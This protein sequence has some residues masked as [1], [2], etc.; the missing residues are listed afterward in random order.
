MGD[1]L[2]MVFI[3][4]SIQYNLESQ[5]LVPVIY[6]DLIILVRHNLRTDIGR[7]QNTTHYFIY[8]NYK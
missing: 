8:T 1:V 4:I 5:N 3:L 6:H 2:I 7:S